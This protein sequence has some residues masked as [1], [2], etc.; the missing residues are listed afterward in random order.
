MEK[1]SARMTDLADKRR[2]WS[3]AEIEN[4][5]ELSAAELAACKQS[6]DEEYQRS[7]A[8]RLKLDMSAEN[9]PAASW[10]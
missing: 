1:P 3:G 7:V 2:N 8:R 10:T 6:L 9:P 4:I 5:T